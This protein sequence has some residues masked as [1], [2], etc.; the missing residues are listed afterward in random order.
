VFVGVCVCVYLSRRKRRRRADSPVFLRV[1]FAGMYV[2][3]GQL[4][5]LFPPRRVRRDDGV[6][7]VAL[8]VCV[9]C[10]LCA[11][12]RAIDGSMR[13]CLDGHS[14]PA[15]QKARGRRNSSMRGSGIMHEVMVLAPLL[16]TSYQMQGKILGAGRSCETVEKKVT[17]EFRT[18][19]SKAVWSNAPN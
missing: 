11:C 13:G 4:S 17:V 12:A 8:S 1:T 15:T 9:R 14:L 10:L 18:P 16:R 7:L 19:R 2:R 3:K 6:A 5:D